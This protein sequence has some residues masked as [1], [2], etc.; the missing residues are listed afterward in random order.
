MKIALIV[1]INHYLN[2][3][4]LYGC[5]NDAYEVKSILERNADGSVNFDCRLLTALSEKD[6]IERGGLKDA[7][8]KLFSTKAEIALFYFAG[9]GHI[10]ATGGYLLASDAKRGDDGLSLNDVLLFA[11]QSPATNKV[12]ILDS[13][14]SGIAGNPPNVKDSAL[15]VEGITVLT[16]STAEQYASEEDASGVFTSLLVDALSG[17][18]A[19]ILGEITPGSVY[20]HID[21]SL[22]AWEQRPIFKTNVRNFVSLREVAPAIPLQDIRRIVEFFPRAGFEFKL[23]PTFEPELKGRDQGMPAPIEQHTKIFALLQKYNRLN[24]LVPV[25]A[26]HMWH[27]AMESKSCKLTA[28]GEH[29]RRLV[30]KNRI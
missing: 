19:N 15:L 1:G 10:E 20:A 27:A 3:T 28:L 6:K 25:G 23:D 8:E 4:G 17:S 26:P 7:V 22:G 11:N 21:Q 18:A 16:A 13:C 2:G 29:Y 12:I 5:V 24:L 14:H 9:H 30:H